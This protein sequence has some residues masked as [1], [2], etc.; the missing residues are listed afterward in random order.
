MNTAN[1]VTPA[2]A[3]DRPYI[4]GDQP[5]AVREAM[6]AFSGVSID[7]DR[8]YSTVN[9]MA[10]SDGDEA[11]LRACLFSVLELLRPIQCE[12]RHALDLVSSNRRAAA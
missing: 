11:E 4:S 2:A 6:Q 1:Q 8:V 7:L 10:T 12:A 9:A 3:G 5:D